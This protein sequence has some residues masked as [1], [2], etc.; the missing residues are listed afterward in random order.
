M[1]RLEH[2]PV[3]SEL[4]RGQLC[5][6]IV[7]RIDADGGVFVR[8]SNGDES[9]TRV[10]GSVTSLEPAQSVLLLVEPG[11]DAPPIIVSTIL[12]RVPSA[13]ERLE[14]SASK[15]LTLRCGDASIELQ[16]DGT[17]EIHGGYVE[18]Y[19]EGVHRI[20]GAQVRIN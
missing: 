4:A 12:D 17:I 10:A 14:L 15:H 8:L 13:P 5:S 2:P 1:K 3:A 19:A 20:K 9:P 16:A 6:A 18:S 7:A 11:V